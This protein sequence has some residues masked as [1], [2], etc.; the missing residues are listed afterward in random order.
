[1]KNKLNIETIKLIKMKNSE[2]NFLKYRSGII[3]PNGIFYGC[4][5][6]GHINLIDW[7]FDEGKIIGVNTKY[8]AE[9]FIYNNG[10]IRLTYHINNNI[11]F[12]LKTY[13][14][15]DNDVEVQI[16]NKP[17][18]KQFETIIAYKKAKNEHHLTFNGQIYMINEFIDAYNNDELPKYMTCGGSRKMKTYGQKVT[19]LRIMRD[20]GFPVPEFYDISYK[21]FDKDSYWGI[22]KIIGQKKIDSEKVIVRS[23][24]MVSMPGCLKSFTVKNNPKSIERALRKVEKSIESKRAQYFFEKVEVSIFSRYT[25]AAV[26]RKINTLLGGAGIAY[27]NGIKMKGDFQYNIDASELLSNTATK[28]PLSLN[29]LSDEKYD[30]LFEYM[31]RLYQ[32]FKNPIKIEFGWEADQKIWIWQ[33]KNSIKTLQ[34]E[35]MIKTPEN[36][37]KI[38]SGKY[39]NWSSAI[40]TVAIENDLDDFSQ[41]LFVMNGDGMKE[42]ECFNSS[43]IISSIGSE[44]SHDADLASIFGIA[45]INGF[46]FKI[47]NNKIIFPNGN[48]LSVGDKI[49]INRREIYKINQ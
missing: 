34:G 36:V 24:P 13:Y 8:S 40:G 17:T 38:A 39:T 32:I 47:K 33:V 20:N 48:Q 23:S 6:E 14:Y 35:F 28:Q 25:G 26:Q 45:N 7:L 10:W 19:N 42:V 3:D 2:K 31:N 43:A 49:Y 29:Q 16:T 4:I 15:D 30:V 11:E 37:T 9:K 46:D 5:D 44:F 12:Q 21:D 22:D 18:K 41:I 1:M 27:F